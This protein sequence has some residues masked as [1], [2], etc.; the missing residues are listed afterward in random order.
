MAQG[1][2]AQVEATPGSVTG[3]YMSGARCIAVPHPR[4]AWK[5]ALPRAQADEPSDDAHPAPDL[6]WQV[7]RVVNAS[8]NNLKGVT[9]TSRSGC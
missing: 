4:R 5:A 9:W 3:A 1:T 2:C 7:L 8:G 6:P